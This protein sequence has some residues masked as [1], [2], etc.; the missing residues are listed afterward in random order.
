VH[1]DIGANAEMLLMRHSEPITLII[2]MVAG[3]NGAYISNEYPKV[4]IIILS[5][6]CCRCSAECCLQVVQLSASVTPIALRPGPPLLS[7]LFPNSQHR[8]CIEKM[9]RC[10]NAVTT[11][12][13][14]TNYL[15]TSVA[16]SLRRIITFD[17][18]DVVL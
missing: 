4:Q 8:D 14:D 3:E 10:S 6:R 9:K 18:S 5:L 11:L 17:I 15:P 12:I 2:F 16:F 7:F 1:C 13:A